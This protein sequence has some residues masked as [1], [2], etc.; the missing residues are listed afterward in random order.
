MVTT[1]QPTQPKTTPRRRDRTALALILT[2]LAIVATVLL[3]PAPKTLDEDLYWALKVTAPP[4][5]V[6]L[7]GDSRIYRGLSPTIM[8]ETLT[9]RRILNYAWDSS[10][11]AADYLRAID[12]HLDPTSDRRAVVLGVSPWSLTPRSDTMTNFD[13]MQ[14]KSPFE[15]Q[16]MLLFGGIAS[17]FNSLITFRPDLEGKTYYQIF[18]E[19]GWVAT[20]LTPPDPAFAMPSYRKNFTDNPVSPRMIDGL[21]AQVRAWRQ[22]GVRV[23]AFRPPTTAPMI[24]LENTLGRFDEEDFTRQFIAAGGTWLNMP[25]TGVYECYDGSHISDRAAVKLSTA[26]AREMARAER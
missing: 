21:L 7:A 19:D 1:T 3:R 8:R 2:V 22:A 13:E 16:T 14:Q 11:F 12:A 17:R 9:D 15:L 6:V 26:I 25:Q 20:R 23:Y 5:E 18:H 10:G 4:A 24:E